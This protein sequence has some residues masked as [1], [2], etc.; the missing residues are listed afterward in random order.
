M[1]VQHQYWA[2]DNRYVLFCS[3]ILHPAVEQWKYA[4][5]FQQHRFHIQT[6]CARSGNSTLLAVTLSQSRLR[7]T[8]LIQP[9]AS[10]A[11]FRY[12]LH[13]KKERKIRKTRC[14]RCNVRPTWSPLRPSSLISQSRSFSKSSSYSSW[15]FVQTVSLIIYHRTE[16]G[17]GR[18]WR[19]AYK[20]FSPCTHSHC[21]TQRKWSQAWDSTVTM[22]SSL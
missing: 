4:A 5:A 18:M 17:D 16:R 13:A 19:N 21:S 20:S 12:I 9:A 7:Y 1:K 14:R 2:T 22:R 11:A 3:S 6:R 10:R 8:H 15:V